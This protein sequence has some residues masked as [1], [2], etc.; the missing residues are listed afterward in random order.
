M[1]VWSHKL[2]DRHNLRE[3]LGLEKVKGVAKGYTIRYIS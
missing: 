3:C 2:F 1:Q